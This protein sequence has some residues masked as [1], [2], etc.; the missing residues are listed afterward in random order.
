MDRRAFIASIVGAVLTA[1]L[2]VQARQAGKIYRVGF[3][4]DSPAV[5][6]Y[7]LEGFRQGLRDLGWAEGR[8]IVVEYRWAE[9]RFDR[10]PGLAEE[11]VRLKVDVIVA[12]TSIYAGAALTVQIYIAAP[13]P[14]WTRS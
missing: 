2:G 13:P 10:L 1:P 9:G 6:P 5:W 11:L 14:M 3:L 4:W 7:A 12:P 8:N